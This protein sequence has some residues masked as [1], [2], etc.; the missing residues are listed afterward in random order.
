MVPG[1]EE[2]ICK[3]LKSLYG[4]K[5]VPK[6]WHGKLDNVLLCDVFLLMMLINVCTLN[7]KM[8]NVSLYVYIWM[9]C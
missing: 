8:V 3:L 6:Q 5:Q 7:L 2:K 4:I 1:Q 9:T